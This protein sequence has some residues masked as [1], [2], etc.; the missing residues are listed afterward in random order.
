MLLHVWRKSG[1]T[2]RT[3]LALV[4]TLVATTPRRSDPRSMLVLPVASSPRLIL[5]S[6]LLALSR[7]GVPYSRR[8]GPF[9]PG[10]HREQMDGITAAVTGSCKENVQPVR[11]GFLIL[12][13]LSHLRHMRKD[14]Q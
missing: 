8:P 1:A 10:E 2:V 3:S 14:H 11:S 12:G 13:G 6:G 5:S 7:H 9:D 4:D